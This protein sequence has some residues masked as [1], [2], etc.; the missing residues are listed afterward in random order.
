MNPGAKL[1]LCQVSFT[2]G[3]EVQKSGDRKGN[4]T[5]SVCAEMSIRHGN[6]RRVISRKAEN[7]MLQ[8]IYTDT[9]NASW[10]LDRL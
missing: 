10:G 5:E 8:F 1:R 3:K 2:N 6:T 7:P 4:A 9:H